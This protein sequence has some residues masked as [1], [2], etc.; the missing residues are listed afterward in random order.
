[1]VSH[2]SY[3]YSY[4]NYNGYVEKS[5]TPMGGLG[6]ALAITG[7]LSTG[8]GIPLFIIGNKMQKR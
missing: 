5:G 2:D 6:A 4:T 1:M 3:G 7:G 8:A